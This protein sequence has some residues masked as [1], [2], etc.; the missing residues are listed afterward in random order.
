M[1]HGAS[2]EHRENSPSRDLV[3]CGDRRILQ[4]RRD[5]Q[6]GQEV[7]LLQAVPSRWRPD[8]HWNCRERCLP[9]TP[10]PSLSEM[11][12]PSTRGL[13]FP[14]YRRRVDH[15]AWRVHP[16]SE[17]FASAGLGSPRAAHKSGLR[18]MA[19]QLDNTST[20]SF[21]GRLVYGFKGKRSFAPWLTES[22][23]TLTTADP[24]FPRFKP[25]KQQGGTKTF[26]RGIPGGT[27]AKG[28]QSP[29]GRIV[30]AAS[31]QVRHGTVS[32]SSTWGQELVEI[33]P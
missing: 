29:R 21:F 26:L 5:D 33:R 4:L 22:S 27:T 11:L 3:E 1:T 24:S 6:A 28:W 30:Q 32:L 9:R 14:P 10:P 8:L 31:P 15:D 16:A 19:R 18:R 2:T 7:P 12:S 23:S 20:S 25:S 13:V 17:E